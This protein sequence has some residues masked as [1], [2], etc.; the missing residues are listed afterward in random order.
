MPRGK[1][2]ASKNKAVQ[3]FQDSDNSDDEQALDLEGDMEIEDDEEI[4]EDAAFTAEDYLKYGD[5]GGSSTGVSVLFIL[6]Y[7]DLL[8]DRCFRNVRE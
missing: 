2:F 8:S 5:I 7:I 3:F 4:D 1:K 6:I